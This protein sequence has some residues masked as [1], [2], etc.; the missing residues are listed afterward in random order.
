LR[1]GN[2]VPQSKQCQQ[3][4]TPPPEASSERVIA[5]ELHV[6]QFSFGQSAILR[7]SSSMR[8]GVGLDAL[9]RFD[10]D[11]IS[12]ANVSYLIVLEGINNIGDGWKA[13]S[14]DPAPPSAQDVIVAYQQIVTRAHAHN[15]T[16]YGATLLPY[17]SGHYYSAA[18]EAI[19]QQVDTWIRNSG[20]FDTVLDFDKVVQDPNQPLM[21][22]PA[23]DSGGHLHPNGAVTRPWV[24]IPLNLFSKS[25]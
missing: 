19:R 14:T 15:I 22:L 16:V 4:L 12:Q 18:G 20:A 6:G 11:I 23:I 13:N 8:S 1:P 7:M 2:S 5:I 21:L 3:I 17:Q 9:A 10:R 24:S 25:N